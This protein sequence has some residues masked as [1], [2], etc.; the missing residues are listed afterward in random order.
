MVWAQDQRRKII[1]K[2]V[3]SIEIAKESGKPINFETF[4]SIIQDETGCTDRKAKEYLKTALSICAAREGG[5]D[6]IN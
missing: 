2:I 4:T 1:T 6:G 5:K 3:T